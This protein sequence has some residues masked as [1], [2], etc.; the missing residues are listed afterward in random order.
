MSYRAKLRLVIVALLATSIGLTGAW[1][2]SASFDNAL[3][4]EVEA[5]QSEERMAL[6]ALAAQQRA[7]NG[8]DSLYRMSGAP[9]LYERPAEAA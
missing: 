8:E 5:A 9:A 7:A 6:Y 1:L 2:I 3:A 4:R